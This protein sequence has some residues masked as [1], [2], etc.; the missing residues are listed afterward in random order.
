[1]SNATSAPTPRVAF[2]KSSNAPWVVAA[3][4][5]LVTL[6]LTAKML[7]FYARNDTP[8]SLLLVVFVSWWLSLVG[9]VVLLP[10]D[11]AIFVDQKAAGT[12]TEAPAAVMALWKTVYWL[13][14]VLSWVVA[15]ILQEYFAAGQFSAR[16]RLGAALKSN[17]AQPQIMSRYCDPSF[18]TEN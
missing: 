16:A 11:L 3:I 5:A 8:K 13:T 17:P 14:F 7:R 15:P 18:P 6:L 9:V 10:L 1:M 2:S 12:Q 4:G